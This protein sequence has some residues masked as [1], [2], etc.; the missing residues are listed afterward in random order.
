M[1]TQEHHVGILS[2]ESVKSEYLWS[3]YA[4]FYYLC[5]LIS[6][7][8]IFHRFSHPSINLLTFTT[9]Y[10]LWSRLAYGFTIILSVSK[11]SRIYTPP[12]NIYQINR[13]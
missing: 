12:D 8:I 4:K 1:R 5:L 9:Q 3:K 13:I 7:V 11:S 6:A 10:F 2:L